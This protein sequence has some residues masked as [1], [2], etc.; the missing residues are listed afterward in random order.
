M[1]SED[2]VLGVKSTCKSTDALQWKLLHYK[3]QVTNSNLSTSIRVSDF[4]SS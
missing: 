1:I 2:H 3:L 4:N